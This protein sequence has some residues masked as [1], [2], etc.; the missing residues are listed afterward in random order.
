MAVLRHQYR[1]VRGFPDQPCIFCAGHD[2]G[3]SPRP[4]PPGLARYRNRWLILPLLPCMRKIRVTTRSG[5][6]EVPGCHAEGGYVRMGFGVVLCAF[7]VA[8][9][10]GYVAILLI[11][12]L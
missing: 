4:L 3:R 2:N 10:W 11:T 6:K 9:F 5:T 1:K 12:S 7:L 8:A